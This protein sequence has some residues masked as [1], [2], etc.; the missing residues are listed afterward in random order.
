MA[1]THAPTAQ[2][3]YLNELVESMDKPMSFSNRLLCQFDCAGTNP[4]C[5]SFA[6]YASVHWK[7]STL[8]ERIYNTCLNNLPVYVAADERLQF[9]WNESFLYRNSGLH[10]FEYEH[11]I[12]IGALSECLPAAYSAAVLRCLG[13]RWE[14]KDRI[15]P[16]LASWRRTTRGLDGILTSSEFALVMDDRMRLDPYGVTSAHSKSCTD[17]LLPPA[18]FAKALHALGELSIAGSGELTLVGGNFLG[19][20]AAMAELFLSINVQ[21]SSRDGQVLY[22]TKFESRAVLRL[23]FVDDLDLISTLQTPSSEQTMLTVMSSAD[24]SVHMTPKIPFTGRVTWEGLLS[25]VF[26]QKFHLIAH[27]ESKTLVQSLGGVA[28]LF[29]LLAEDPSIPEEVVSKENK[30]N[31]ASYGLGLIQTLCNWFPELRHLQGRLERLQ[32]LDRHGVTERCNSGAQRLISLCGCD[33]CSMSTSRQFEQEIK[34]P[35]SFCLL[36][37]ME[38][39]LNMGLAMSRITVVPKLYP[40]RAGIHCIY[41]RQVQKLIE[42][43]KLLP[44]NSDTQH[45][46]SQQPDTPSVDA[47]A[48]V[49]ILFGNDWNANCSRR[50]QNACAIFSGSWPEHDLPENLVGLSHEGICAYM[51]GVQ[52]GDKRPRR[53]DADVIR[54]TAGHIAWKQNCFSRASLGQPQGILS[55]DYSWEEAECNHLSQNLYVK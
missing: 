33:V 23:I 32:T 48:R 54:V 14:D 24:D 21:V 42:A 55:T 39:I 20:F 50:L 46:I 6:R 22:S 17:S 9:G 1:N 45:D 12:L 49:K 30:Q 27:Q 8:G 28:R 29:A 51:I 38:T 36:A 52:H 25:K 31:P 43:K 53:Q 10:H 34:V 5:I 37:I 47:W 19:W 15:N 18:E 40:S 41:Q 13:A 2:H 44:P 11:L 7:P 16:S 3:K 26:E 35:Q 4:Y